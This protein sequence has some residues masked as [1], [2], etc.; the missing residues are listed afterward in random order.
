[1][2]ARNTMRHYIAE[3]LPQSKEKKNLIKH[4]RGP[5]GWG[6]GVG[7]GGWSSVTLWFVDSFWEITKTWSQ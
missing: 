1:M 7:G 6:V 5:V 2:G 3:V 4:L